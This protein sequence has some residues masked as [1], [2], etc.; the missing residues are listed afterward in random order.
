M[1]VPSCL[2][3]S[4]T[5]PYIFNNAIKSGGPIYGPATFVCHYDYLRLTLAPSQVEENIVAIARYFPRSRARLSTGQTVS[6]TVLAIPCFR[7]WRESQ[8]H[9]NR[10]KACLC[11]SKCS[12]EHYFKLTFAPASSSFALI[13]SASSFFTPALSSAGAP[14]TRSLAS[15]R[16]SPSTSL[17]TLITAI[18]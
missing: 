9:K 12:K 13:D 14:S 8:P 18:F 1:F 5:I 10:H 4:F 2:M 16:P 3:S 7:P 15:L 6:Q 17:T 11:V